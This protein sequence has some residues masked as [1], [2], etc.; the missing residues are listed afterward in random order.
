MVLRLFVM[1]LV[2]IGLP[3]RPIEAADRPTFTLEAP[4]IVVQGGGKV[5]IYIVPPVGFDFNRPPG[6]WP[7]PYPAYP[8]A[9]PAFPANPV[10][11]SYS[12]PM[13]YVPPSTPPVEV[14]GIEL[15]PGGRLVIEV[16][17]EDAEVYVDALRLTSWTEHGY[18][19]GLLAGRHRVDV[20]RAGMRPWSQ[21]V[22][23]PAGGGVLVSVQLE[24]QE[25]A[26]PS[27][28]SDTAPVR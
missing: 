9:H 15:K 4:G 6:Y 8:Y 7:Y 21:E 11:P 23:V 22:Q 28:K 20:R 27:E 13:P 1:L 19:L 26:G 14:R 3:I 16:K 24:P 12:A 17:P 5:A 2:L 25:G 18:D 10:H